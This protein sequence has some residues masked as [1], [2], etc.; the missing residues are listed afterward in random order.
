MPIYEYQCERCGHCF[1]QLIFERDDKKVKCP[2]CGK[3][4]VRKLLSC[5][6]LLGDSAFSKCVSD[7]SS[8]FS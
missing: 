2:E 1:E 5:A 7:P 4:K 6:S 8:G 3:T